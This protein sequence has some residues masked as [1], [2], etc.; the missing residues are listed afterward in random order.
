MSLSRTS[1]NLDESQRNRAAPGWWWHDIDPGQGITTSGGKSAAWLAREPQA[2]Q[3]T[4]LPGRGAMAC[5][6]ASFSP[7]VAQPPA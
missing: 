4:D 7:A 2:L 1:S 5:H 6:R 3:L